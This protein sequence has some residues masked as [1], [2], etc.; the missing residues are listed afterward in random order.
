[1]RLFL[2]GYVGFCRLS[3]R[4]LDF[5]LLRIKNKEAKKTIEDYVLF[6]QQEQLMAAHSADQMVRI[7]PPKINDYK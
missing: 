7:I 4:I 2:I 3:I 1:M 5:C 6:I